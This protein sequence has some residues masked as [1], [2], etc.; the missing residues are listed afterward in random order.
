LETWNVRP[1]A[2]VLIQK[3]LVSEFKLGSNAAKRELSASRP[4]G[5]QPHGLLRRL[6][7]LAEKRSWVGSQK[8]GILAPIESCKSGEQL[9]VGRRRAV[10]A[11]TYRWHQ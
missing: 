9:P 1:R 5:S 4:I 6:L 8:K 7:L 11:G 10:M 2:S 3:L